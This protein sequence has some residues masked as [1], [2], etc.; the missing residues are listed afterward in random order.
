M[1]VNKSMFPLQNGFSVISQMQ[2]RFATLQTQLGTGMKANSLAEMGRD[3]PMSLSARSRLDKIAGF[4][5]SIDTVNL[6]LSFLDKSMSRFDSM[7]GEARNSA[8]PGQYGSSDINMATVPR[9]SEARFDEIITMLQEDVAGRYLFGGNVTDT[10]PVENARVLL[11]G[12]GGRLGFKQ[13]LAERQ[14]ADLGDGLGRLELSAGAAGTGVVTVQDDRSHP[15][16]FKLSTISTTAQPTIAVTQPGAAGTVSV[17]FNGQPVPGQS[18]TLGLTLPDGSETQLTL[19]ASA[20]AVP[21]PGKFAIGSDADATA[22]NF[23][24]ALDASLRESGGSTL[25]AAS[26]F[27]AAG[28][29][30][31]ETGV[32]QRP[33]GGPP[34]TAL[35][36][37]DPDEVV[38]WYKGEVGGNARSSVTAKVDDSTTIR[39]GM[40]ATESGVLRLVQSQAAMAAMHFPSEAEVRAKPELEQLRLNAQAQPEGELRQAALDGYEAEVALLYRQSRGLFDGMATRQQDQMSEGRNSEPGSIE[41]VTM[42]LGIARAATNNAAKRHTDY[43]SQLENLLNDVETVSPE[44]VAMEILALQTRLQA[45]YQVTA[46]VSQMSLTN[47]V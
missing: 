29:F 23:K 34:A 37:A 25:M 27:A 18:V 31:S 36:D 28:D 21:G 38:F 12:Q 19:V 5:S 1:I 9:Q 3:L 7:E 10:P 4:S 17:R 42:D 47:F 32:P 22:A 13:V 6:R 15:F 20:D 43:K 35:V 41:Q 14:A 2:E 16:G 39:Y 33:A 40:R 24:G 45:S 46:M 11:N 26:S 30:F 8:L 44:N